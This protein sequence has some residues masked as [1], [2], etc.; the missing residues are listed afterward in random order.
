MGAKGTEIIFQELLD[1]F[2]NII[3]SEQVLQ[4]LLDSISNTC[5]ETMIFY[6][7]AKLSQNGPQDE[8]PSELASINHAVDHIMSILSSCKV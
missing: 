7:K 8:D 2:H 6:K 3:D 4:E 1:Q 5:N